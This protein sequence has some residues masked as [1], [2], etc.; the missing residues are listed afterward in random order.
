MFSLSD[1]ERKFCVGDN[2]CV[3]DNSIVAPQLKGTTGMV[4]RVDD[5][6]VVVLDQSSES[7]FTV[8]FDSLATSIGDISKQ[9]PTNASI[10]NDTPMKGDRVVVTEGIY[11]CEFGEVNE[12]DGMTWTV[13]F[14]SDSRQTTITVLMGA[15]AFTPNPTALQYTH[16]RG[17]HVVAGDIVQVVRGD[18]L[19][20]SDTLHTEFTTSITY[21]VRIGGRE[22]HEP[23]QHLVGTLQS[24]SRD[25]CKVVFQGRREEFLRTHIVSRK[26]VLLNGFRL[27]QNQQQEF[28]KLVQSS[29]IR[30]P[31]ITPPTTPCHSPSPDKSHPD[32]PAPAILGSL[33]DAPIDSLEINRCKEGAR[34]DPWVFNEDDKEEHQLHP[35]DATSCSPADSL[36]AAIVHNP[37]ITA[38]YCNWHMKFCIV[39]ASSSHWISYLNRLVDTVAPDPFVLDEGLVKDGEIAI[40]YSSRMKNK[41]LK[42]GTICLKD[43]AP[44]PPSGPNKKFTLIRGDFMGSVHTTGKTSKDKSKITTVEG[45][46]SITLMHA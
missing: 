16:K 14:F 19:Y 33:W 45:K 5:D 27:P 11:V 29:F 2:V 20:A 35:P 9:G 1:L 36:T 38:L 24:L 37:L 13:A 23:M 39:K 32:Q 22:D 41:G 30:S 6:T 28:N 40:K 12:V 43:I 18:R 46:V 34:T 21:V 15:M 8:G 25:T 44:E 26:G 17:Y 10:C 42:V 3:L 7:E 4:V 31:H